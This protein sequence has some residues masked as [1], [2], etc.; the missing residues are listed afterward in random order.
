LV[1]FIASSKLGGFWSGFWL[2]LWR[3]FRMKML[4]Q[5]LEFVRVTVTNPDMVS[6]DP[7]GDVVQFA[8][9]SPGKTPTTWFAGSWDTS[10]GTYDAKILVGPSG[11]VTL[12]KG[13]YDVYLRITDNPEIP[14]RLAGNLTI[15]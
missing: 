14:V 15:E 10:A 9:V 5:S 8:F 4:A 3:T 7:S 1:R 11:T 2:E 12:S 6:F 13:R